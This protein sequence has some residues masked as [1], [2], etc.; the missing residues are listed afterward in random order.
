MTRLAKV[1]LYFDLICRFGKASCNSSLFV[2]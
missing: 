1:S 2:K